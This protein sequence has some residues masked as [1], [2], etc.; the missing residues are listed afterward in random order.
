MWKATKEIYGES[1]RFALALP[2]LVAIPVFAELVQHGIEYRFGMYD[3]ITG[4]EAA[5]NDAARDLFGD[6]K[7]LT[8]YLMGYW[9]VRFMAFD[10]DAKRTVALPRRAVLLFLPV[11]A[12]EMARMLLEESGVEF[13]SAR[14]AHP[15]LKFALPAAWILATVVLEVYLICWKTGAALGNSRLTI[16]TSFRLMRGN[17]W[18]SFG[19]TCLIGLPLMIMHLALCSGAVGQPTW[20]LVAILVAD[21][22]LVG[23]LATVL[24]ANNYVIARRAVAAANIDLGGRDRAWSNG[25]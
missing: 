3:S 21:A 6:A 5:R 12:F 4:A 18:W 7:E 11:L 14:F 19:L 22:L 17:F 16:P 25:H 13:L 23:G 1:W 2:W 20:L 8:L 24:I 15:V 10:H 9:V